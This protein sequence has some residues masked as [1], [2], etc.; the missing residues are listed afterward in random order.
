MWLAYSYLPSI[1]NS[2]S[3]RLIITEPQAEQGV[4][5]TDKSKDLHYSNYNLKSNCNQN[6]P[7]KYSKSYPQVKPLIFIS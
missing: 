1:L 5:F 2:L 6:G 7:P 3:L 4:M